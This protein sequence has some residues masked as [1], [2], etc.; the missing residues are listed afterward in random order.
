MDTIYYHIKGKLDKVRDQLLKKQNVVAVG[1]GYKT[2]EGHT[3]GDLSII[4][5]VAD[6]KPISKLSTADLIPRVIEGIPT[7]VFNSGVI[8]VVSNPKARIR[9]VPAGCSISHTSVT[10]GTLGCW[11]KKK[12]Q[13]YL[14]SN[15]HVIANNNE[16]SPGD[17]IIQPGSYDGGLAPDDVIAILSEFVPINF[18]EDEI[19]SAGGISGFIAGFLNLLYKLSGSRTRIKVYKEQSKTNLCD[20]AIAHPLNAEEVA[21]EVLELGKIQGLKEGK[22]DMKIRKFGRTTA[23]TN[24]VITQTDLS[25]VV[26]YG[27]N[28]TALFS[29]QL[30]A[31][32]MSQGGDSGSAVLDEE[33]NLVGLLFAGSDATTIINRIQNV[34]SALDI[35]LP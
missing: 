7:D 13:L 22:L 25:V 27:Y 35:T 31:G 10:A 21:L 20:A 6:K 14:L 24:G 3:T 33:N 1:I 12:D 9:P 26:N 15:N 32:A 11:V 19:S 4:C 28:K 2:V 30:M 18:R 5:S 16:A 17:L 29:D 8:N 23:L 34:F